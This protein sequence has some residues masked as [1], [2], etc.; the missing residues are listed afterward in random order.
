M[1]ALVKVMIIIF[2]ISYVGMLSPVLGQDLGGPIRVA[3]FQFSQMVSSGNNVYVLYQQNSDN[4][5]HFH[6]YFVKSSDA[7]KSF[8][9]SIDL[10]SAVEPIV[11]TFGDNVFLAWETGFTGWPPSHVVFA[12]SN[13]RGNMFGSQVILDNSPDSSS[14]I[15]QLL[16]DGK[17]LF[18]VIDELGEKPPYQS[19]VYL[20]TSQDNGTTWGKKVELL[21]SALLENPLG[22]DTSIQE[23]GDKLVVIGEKK[24]DCENPNYCQYAI[25]LRTST[26]MGSTFGPEIDIAKSWNPVRL[27]TI[28]S[29]NNIYVVWVDGTRGQG[30]DLLFSKSNDDGNTFST[31]I[32]LGQEEGEYDWPHMMTSDKTVY[33]VWQYN[34]ENVIAKE[35]YGGVLTPA[36]V[37]GIF[38][39]KSTDG[40][41]TFSQPLNLSGDI[42][43]SYFSG[44]SSSA[45]NVYSSWTSKHGDHVQV[46]F[47]RSTDNGATFGDPVDLTGRSD[48]W[49]SQIVS[50][51]DNVYIAGDASDGNMIWLKASND[52]GANF[53]P[54]LTLNS[55]ISNPEYSP[56]TQQKM[57]YTENHQNPDTSNAIVL[58]EVM[59][60]IAGGVSVGVFL[61]TR[62]R[63]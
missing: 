2:S 52:D 15:T 25:F 31:P 14:V 3:P 35:H 53:G 7:G 22:Y 21:P 62:K 18:A 12:K 17:H 4:G 36:Y 16:S 58:V 6:S 39:A 29:G 56:N 1:K 61:F 47:S 5:A 8:G 9:N 28:S 55:G 42:G 11:T 57:A 10:G 32:A 54:L 19:D 50:S 34:N 63:K 48:S 46:F 59:V 26:D 51:G 41:N 27:Q 45:G 23:I 40:G 60:P 33:I 43:T 38:F 24:L 44:I 37:S 13:D 20:I 49:F 30:P